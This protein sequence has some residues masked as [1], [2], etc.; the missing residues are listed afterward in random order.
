MSR[1]ALLAAVTVVA[2]LL[3]ANSLAAGGTS[4]TSGQRVALLQRGAGLYAAN[5][6]QCHG[7]N[8]EGKSHPGPVRG[9]NNVAG[10]GPSLHGVGALAAD[11]YLSTGYMPLLN[12]YDQPRRSRV[13]FSDHDLKALVAYVASF[14]PGPP[15]PQPDPASGS[16]SRGLRIFTQNCAG[17]HQIATAGGYLP[18][19]V[20]PPLEGDTPRQ[21]A[22][23]VRIGPNL[24]PKFSTS[25]LPNRD[26][27]SV[28]AYIQ[29]ARSPDDRGGWPLAH[30]GP[31]P[32]GLVAWFVAG[33]VLVGVTL[34]VGRRIA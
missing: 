18:D 9:V 31:V 25:L 29:Y 3:A 8:G 34:T 6:S 2:L 15:I 26:V 32:E 11:F 4:G 10:I 7:P 14:S 27:N 22:E 30:I 28:I 1:W 23:A 13:L 21:I 17:C 16:V 24:M 19:S 33:V 20:A 12:P 5:C